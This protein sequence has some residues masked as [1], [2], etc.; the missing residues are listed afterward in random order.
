M[1]NYLLKISIITL[2]SIFVYSCSKDNLDEIKEESNTS[3]DEGLVISI[4]KKIPV[5]KISSVEEDINS[6]N[7]SSQNFAA[8]N[9][10]NFI[11]RFYKDGDHFYT[12]NQSEGFNA[13]YTYEGILGKSL[14]ASGSQI[15][16]TRWYN[17]HSGDRYMTQSVSSTPAIYT[18][19]NDQWHCLTPTNPVYLCDLPASPNRIPGTNITS[20]PATPNGDWRYEGLLGKSGGTKAIYSYYNSSANDHYFTN[21]YN[22]LGNGNYGYIYEGIVFYL[23]N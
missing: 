9:S 21:N 13:G 5:F 4:E 6:I 23:Y 19:M 7:K 15:Q 20:D 14:I 10:Y 16:L 22:D 17:I 2:I 3:V 11:Y 1:K 18:N 12:V 8:Q